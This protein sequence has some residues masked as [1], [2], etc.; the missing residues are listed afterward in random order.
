MTARIAVTSVARIAADLFG[1]LIMLYN[2]SNYTYDAILRSLGVAG[3]LCH[4]L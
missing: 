4:H 2:H 1:A 3:M